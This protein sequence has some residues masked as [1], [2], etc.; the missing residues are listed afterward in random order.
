MMSELK[1]TGVSVTRMPTF[2]RSSRMKFAVATRMTLSELVF[3]WKLTGWPFESSRTPSPL[4]SLK[5]MLASKRF[6]SATS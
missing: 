1:S 6:D 2:A 5:P 4:A 3:S